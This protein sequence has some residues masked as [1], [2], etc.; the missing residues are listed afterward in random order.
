VASSV[1]QTL[2]I[3]A[4]EK[5]FGGV[6]AYQDFVNARYLH[7]GKSVT[8][9]FHLTVFHLVA[10]FFL[11][12]LIWLWRP[13]AATSVFKAARNPRHAFNFVDTLRVIFSQI[14]NCANDMNRHHLPI[15]VPTK[16][17]EVAPMG[18]KLC[19]VGLCGNA[20]QILKRSD[21]ATNFMSEAR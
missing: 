20:R 5:F 10:E 2:P 4:R 6:A 7:C 9:W 19:R 13:E 3:C 12:I 1:S 16:L 17:I 15:A 14:N 11:K 8:S 18:D 21:D